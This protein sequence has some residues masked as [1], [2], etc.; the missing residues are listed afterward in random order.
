M[1]VGRWLGGAGFCS[2]DRRLAGCHWWLAHQCGCP[3]SIC[4]RVLIALAITWACGVGRVS[5]QTPVLIE[6]FE[7]CIS[8]QACGA[9]VID[10]TDSPNQPALYINGEDENASPQ[11]GFFSIGTDAVFCI[12]WQEPCTPGTV[13]GFRRMMDPAHWP[14][15]CPGGDHYVPLEHTYGDPDSPGPI[16]P[17]FPLS[18]FVAV[19][20]VYGDGGFA[21]GLTGT[22]LWLN[23]VDCE[24]EIFQFINYSEESLY[25]ELWT[26]DVIQGQNLIQISPESLIDV[27]DGD[28]L[29]TEIVAI[30]VFIQDTD[31]PPTTVGKWYVD[32]LRIIEPVGGSPPGDWDGDGDVD[33]DD[34]SA[35]LSCVGGPDQPIQDE[36]AVFDADSD[37]DV[38]LVDFGELQV[39]MG[40]AL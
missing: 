39:A 34:Y 22:H 18:D 7:F 23:L 12:N 13:I 19:W 33:L 26:L 35:Y 28:R 30:E 40:Q 24:G 20:D 10:M 2:L 37:G 9:G 14:A 11:E 29:L 31:D 1:T 36:C 5:A 3:I 25:S 27:P 32:N 17:D 4:G 16:E 15:Q 8:D 38:D 6:D 21:D